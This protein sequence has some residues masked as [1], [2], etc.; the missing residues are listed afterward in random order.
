M[1]TRRPEVLTCVYYQPHTK[2]QSTY[3]AK[4]LGT[5]IVLLVVLVTVHR[6]TQVRGSILDY[7]V[8]ESV[9]HDM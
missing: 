5:P 1:L 3:N 2:S 6:W 9:P 4:I 8:L 7:N